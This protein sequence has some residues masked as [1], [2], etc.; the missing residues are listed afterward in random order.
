MRKR[1]LLGEEKD[2]MNQELERLLSDFYVKKEK[3]KQIKLIACII[4]FIRVLPA[5]HVFLFHIIFSFIGNL[6]LQ[7]ERK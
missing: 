4:Y 5:C 7:K 3:K 6:P 2:R 1:R